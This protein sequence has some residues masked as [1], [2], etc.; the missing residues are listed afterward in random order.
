MLGKQIVYHAIQEPIEDVTPEKLAAMDQE[1]ETL[2]TGIKDSKAQEKQIRSEITTLGTKIPTAELRLQVFKLE[3]E[4][5]TLVN[6]LTPLREKSVQ[7][8]TVSSEELARSD[9][10]WKTWQKHLIVRRKICRELWERCTEVLPEGARS[11]EEL[12]ESLGLEGNL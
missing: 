8:R 6:L 1:I 10:E 9:E 4:K 3:E 7:K 11:R 12:W 2:K 5:K